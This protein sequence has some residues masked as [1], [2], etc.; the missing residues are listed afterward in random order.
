MVGE[1]WGGP[2]LDGKKNPVEKEHDATE[3]W[4]KCLGQ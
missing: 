4:C 1:A 2:T 3:E